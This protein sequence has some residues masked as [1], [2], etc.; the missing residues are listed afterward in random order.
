MLVLNTREEEKEPSSSVA[1]KASYLL[2]ELK[3]SERCYLKKN[4]RQGQGED[5]VRKKLAVQG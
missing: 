1:C 3:A 5:P 2:A 4:I